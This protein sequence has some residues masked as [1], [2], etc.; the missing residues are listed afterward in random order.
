[1]RYSVNGIDDDGA[2]ELFETDDR[3]ESIRFV[4]RYVSSGDAGNWPMIEVYDRQ[5]AEDLGMC[6]V[7]HW[8][9]W[10]P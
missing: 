6:V 8:E 9:A 2:T 1:M 4:D 3:D 7:H 5:Y 10:S